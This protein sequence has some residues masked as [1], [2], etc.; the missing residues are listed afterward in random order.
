MYDTIPTLED[1]TPG[2][3]ESL[4]FGDS[5]SGSFILFCYCWDLEGSVYN[6]VVLFSNPYT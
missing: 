1:I 3:V 4:E 5:W 2:N 6:F